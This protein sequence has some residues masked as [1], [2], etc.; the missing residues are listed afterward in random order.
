M[1]EDQKEQ[2]ESE[3]PEWLKKL[4]Q[5]SW[6]AEI[7]IS[8]GAFIGILG[9]L[10]S[11]ESLNYALLYATKLNTTFANLLTASIGLTVLFLAEGFLLHLILRGYWIGLIGMNY[12]FPKGINQEK[13]AF[14]GRFSEFIKGN[15]N[16]PYLIKLDKL[17]SL[18]FA[19][20]F[21]VIFSFTGFFIFISLFGL[22]AF[23]MSSLVELPKFI[24][25]LVVVLLLIFVLSGIVVL[26]DFFT[27]GRLK[28]IKWFSKVYYPIHYLMSR[29]TL[30]F[31]YRRLYY[32][33]VSNIKPWHIIVGLCIQIFSSALLEA[34]VSRLSK[35]IS[36]ANSSDEWAFL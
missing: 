16:S 31:L 2:Q 5:E 9:L 10:N 24:S 15:S 6:Q 18:V 11:M 34:G 26:I 7:L 32:T 1:N 28:R 29:V 19:F 20:T 17:C 21:F 12:V 22:F 13:L 14:R 30:S 25:I 3:T 27:F 4:E 36:P 35:D 33:I 8:G 23:A